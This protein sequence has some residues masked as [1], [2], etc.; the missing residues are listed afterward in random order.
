MSG[1]AFV[2]PLAWLTPAVIP[3][4]NNWI[5]ALPQ[6]LHISVPGLDASPVS[7]VQQMKVSEPKRG[8]ESEGRQP[9][10]AGE[11]DKLANLMGESRQND[12][13]LNAQR[14]VK[15]LHQE[16]AKLKRA[17]SKADKA[18]AKEEEREKREQDRKIKQAEAEARRVASEEAAS[19]RE[20]AAREAEKA[21]HDVA[22]VQEKLEVAHEQ[23]VKEDR[24]RWRQVSQ[25]A[26]QTASDATAKQ[27]AREEVAKKATQK[28]DEARTEAM[29]AK[30]AAR[31]AE[32]RHR[33][34]EKEKTV[35]EAVRKV[36]EMTK[37]RQDA[38]R[39]KVA[40]EAVR[41]AR[42]A[43]R[44]SDKNAQKAT[45]EAARNLR[46]SEDNLR[47]LDQELHPD[48]KQVAS[49]TSTS[50]VPEIP[51]AVSVVSLRSGP[52]GPP[53][54]PWFTMPEFIPPPAQPPS[55]PAPCSSCLR[56]TPIPTEGHV[57]EAQTDFP[58]DP[59]NPCGTASAKTACLASL[60]GVGVS[61]IACDDRCHCNC[62][63]RYCYSQAVQPTAMGRFSTVQGERL[64][65]PQPQWYR[66]G[67]KQ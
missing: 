37:A 49:N 1:L 57:P 38:E 30:E 21:L 20:A 52:S 7:D 31:E 61:D 45:R 26:A 66:W 40:R 11:S 29:A 22:A 24:E 25:E 63:A 12:A 58:I 51:E 54:P 64:P 19:K 17:K 34:A 42:A 46:R 35:G 14:E 65:Q 4:P 6:S 8:V 60:C 47:K 32:Q 41:I 50:E 53:P 16:A 55:T 28:A 43:A 67:G 5:D 33:V 62:Q 15:R 3:A 27:A 18:R 13:I 36:A 59:S 10:T 44:Q 2:A 39:M 23:A 9:L 56:P 48:R